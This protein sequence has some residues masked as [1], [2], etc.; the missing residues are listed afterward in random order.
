[1]QE[2]IFI[3]KR[4]LLANCAFVELKKGS[5][6]SLL[7]PALKKVTNNS[8][9]FYYVTFRID[10]VT[11]SS[12]NSFSLFTVLRVKDNAI[13]KAILVCDCCKIACGICS[14]V[15]QSICTRCFNFG[16][17]SVRFA[18]TITTETEIALPYRFVKQVFYPCLKIRSCFF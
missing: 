15:L 18:P 2:R 5:L 16:W 6:L 13:L 7:A 10:L 11:F 12:S 14:L 9:G 4:G 1:M 17:F 8:F 3:N